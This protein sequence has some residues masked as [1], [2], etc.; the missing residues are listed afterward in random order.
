MTRGLAVTCT[1]EATVGATTSDLVALLAER[2]G[3]EPFV[4]VMGVDKLPETRRLAGT[5]VAEVTARV[6]HRTG[7]ALVFGAVDNLGKG[8]AGQAVQNANL[9]LGFDEGTALDAAPLVP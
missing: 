6:D 9:M 1:A 8:A 7:R 2:Y 4:R 3:G 5:N